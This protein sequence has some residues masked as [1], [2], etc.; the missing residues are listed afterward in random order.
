MFAVHFV[1][2]QFDSA[3]DTQHSQDLLQSVDLLLLFHSGIRCL[4][5]CNTPFIRGVFESVDFSRTGV[6]IVVIGDWCWSLILVDLFGEL[7]LST[8]YGVR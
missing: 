4:K 2:H 8:A 1:S 7:N 5:Y 3:V 6:F